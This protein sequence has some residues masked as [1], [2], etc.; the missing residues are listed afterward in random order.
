MHNCSEC[1][2][3]FPSPHST[4][5]QVHVISIPMRYPTSVEQMHCSPET[6]SSTEKP[7]G[8]MNDAIVHTESGRTLTCVSKLVVVIHVCHL[9]RGNKYYGMELHLYRWR[10]R[11]HLIRLAKSDPIFFLVYIYERNECTFYSQSEKCQNSKNEPNGSARLAL[12]T[13]TDEKKT[14]ARCI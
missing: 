8:L 1:N 2:Q 7:D 10:V 13:G 9:C 14:Y 4:F 5:S 12:L 11:R 3:Q 6:N